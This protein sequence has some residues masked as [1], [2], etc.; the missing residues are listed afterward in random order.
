MQDPTPA[1]LKD[2][3]A[4]IVNEVKDDIAKVGGE[5]GTLAKDFETM[6]MAKGQEALDAFKKIW[7]AA[8]S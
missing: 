2:Q 7:N 8:K 5:V 3:M 4:A 6:V 1:G